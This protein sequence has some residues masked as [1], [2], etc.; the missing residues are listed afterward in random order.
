MTQEQ[1]DNLQKLADFIRTVPQE[2]FSMY[3]YRDYGEQRTHE[4]KTIGCSLGYAPQVLYDN[5]NDVPKYIDL[6]IDFDKI[7]I[8]MFGIESFEREWTWM[9]GLKWIRVDNTP[10]GAADRIEWFLKHGLPE[11]WEEQM[12]GDAPL[13]YV[14][15]NQDNNATQ[16][17]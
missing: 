5:Y 4:C 17:D 13:C 2:K 12:Q 10:T 7:S 15:N 9:F 1:R 11:N 16:E 14:I 8:D 6:I 3:K